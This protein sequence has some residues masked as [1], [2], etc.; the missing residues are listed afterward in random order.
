MKVFIF[1]YNY[2]HSMQFFA[3]IT[4]IYLVLCFDDVLGEKITKYMSNFKNFYGKKQ[5]RL[6]EGQCPSVF[7][8]DLFI[9]LQDP[10]RPTSTQKM[11]P[12]S[13]EIVENGVTHGYQS[14]DC[15]RPR[16]NIRLLSTPELF[17]HIT[18]S[19]QVCSAF[20]TLSIG[21]YLL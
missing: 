20:D 14:Y 16:T 1:Q 15:Y 17:F 10:M 21:K 3:L 6:I 5:C 4:N 8:R 19:I 2:T 9:V 18:F 13:F 11:A 7:G 12:G